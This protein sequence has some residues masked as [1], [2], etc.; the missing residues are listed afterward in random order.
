MDIQQQ[1]GVK[2][3]EG[4]YGCVF[5]PPLKCK[6]RTKAPTGKMVGKLA[7]VETA[8]T[9]VMISATLKKVPAAPEYFI[10]IESSC[11]PAP[12]ENQTD[13]DLSDCRLLD[14]VDLADTLQ[15][16]MS[17]GGKAL[18]YV[19]WTTKDID[20][21]ELG[22][23]LLEAGTLMLIAGVVHSD[24]HTSN[25]LLDTPSKARIIDFGIGWTPESLTLANLLENA[26]K[27]FNPQIS[28]EPPELATINGLTEGQ[29]LPELLEK[30]QRDKITVTHLGI[31]FEKSPEEMWDS[32]RNFLDHS[33]TFRER[34]EIAFLNFFKLYWSKID[35]WSI[36]VILFGLFAKLIH[37][38][39]FENSLEYQTRGGTFV[40]VIKG[41]CTMDP[42]LRLDCAEALQMWAPES[43]ILER[44]DVKA[45]LDDAAKTREA[46][47]AIL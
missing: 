33:W 2:I 10:L 25:I 7:E 43:P 29:R 32:F 28:Q 8:E 26:I 11:E 46:L 41:L 30:L 22:Q 38:P 14:E 40:E 1:G 3:G 36:G 39:A 20:Y 24:L 19:P 37:D 42:G 13:K 12:K 15:V 23:H 9:E 45:W 17:L 31:L 34:T 27:A 35:A 18:T 16:T 47:A 5:A 4:Y 21:Q 44:A 6:S